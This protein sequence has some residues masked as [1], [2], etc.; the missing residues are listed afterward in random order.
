LNIKERAKTARKKEDWGVQGY[1][2]PGNNWLFH[3][4]KTF[5]SKTKKENI[6]EYEARNKKDLPAPN[7]YSSIPDWSKN[8]KGK[9]PKSVRNTLIDQILAQKKLRLPGP[10]TYDLPK[11]EVLQPYVK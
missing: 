6:I 1:Y 9:F 11:L 5:M 2:C 3:R 10:G 4:P 8:N 7:M